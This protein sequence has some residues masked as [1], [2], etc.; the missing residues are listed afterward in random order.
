MNVRRMDSHGGWLAKPAAI[1]AFASSVDGFS[2]PSILK[3]TT[4]GTMVTPSAANAR[5]AKGW[6]VNGSNNWWHTGHLPGTSGLTPQGGPP[7]LPGWQ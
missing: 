7:A 4:I 6:R 3:R 1:V 5:Y 2:R